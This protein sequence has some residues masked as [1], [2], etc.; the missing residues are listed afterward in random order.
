MKM[1]DTCLGVWMLLCAVPP[2]TQV[3][4]VVSIF[5][6]SLLLFLAGLNFGMAIGQ[7]T[8]KVN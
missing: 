5:A 7:A 2:A 8:K 4:W 6:V 1:R 3:D